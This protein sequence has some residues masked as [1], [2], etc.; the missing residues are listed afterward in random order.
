MPPPAQ[1]FLTNWHP[2]IAAEAVFSPDECARVVALVGETKEAGI[3]GLADTTGYRDSKVSWIRPGDEANWVFSRMLD[4]VR[5]ANQAHYQIEIAG[6]TEPLQV[7]EYG[8]EQHYDWHLDIGNGPISVRKLSFIAQL[9]DPA[10][11][12]GGAV[13]IFSAQEPH[14]MPRPQG[15]VIL[16][17]SY[18]LHRVARVTKGVRRSLVG[19]IGGPHFR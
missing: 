1:R 15:S 2:A 14:A 16:F 8:P 4:F 5:Q 6:F 7:A 9:T 10:D 12:E 18:V 11:Y 19:W 17:P 3:K 13:E